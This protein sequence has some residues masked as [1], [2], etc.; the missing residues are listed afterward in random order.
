[1]ASIDRDKLS[2]YLSAHL[3]GEL[4]EQEREALE[5][6]VARD[7]RARSQLEELRQ[8]VELVR[9]LPRRAA[10]PSLLEDLTAAAEREQLLGEPPEEVRRRAPWWASAR[11]LLSAAAAVVITVGGGLYVYFN[12]N[13]AGQRGDVP[14]ET[15]FAAR[16][17]EPV[18][19]EAKSEDSKR[20]GG[21]GLAEASPTVAD[22]L[23][24]GELP[25]EGLAKA[26]VDSEGAPGLR[27]AATMTDKKAPGVGLAVVT[28][29][30]VNGL[31]PAAATSGLLAAQAT[32][33]AEMSTWEQKNDAN[34]LQNTLLVHNFDN[35]SNRLTVLV[36]SEG[37]EQMARAQAANFVV[38]NQYRD[39]A[40]MPEEA[41][42]SNSARAYMEGRPGY[43]YDAGHRAEILFRLPVNEVPALVEALA[44]SDSGARPMQLV[45]GLTLAHGQDEI[46]ELIDRVQR[47]PGE[48][49]ALVRERDVLGPAEG[50]GAYDA[51]AAGEAKPLS[52]RGRAGGVAGVIPA[53]V[54]AE[55]GD[56]PRPERAPDRG[57]A[58]PAMPVK[59]EIG[60]EPGREL[61]E[62]RTGG[63][64][65]PPEQP[66]DVG[67]DLKKMVDR[68]LAGA[69]GADAEEAVKRRAAGKGP[70][71][72]TT[73]RPGELVSK[74][75]EEL[76]RK[77]RRR[78]P[79]MPP[80]AGKAKDAAPEGMVEQ[81]VT[82]VVQFQRASAPPSA[83][84]ATQPA[85][86][87][88]AGVGDGS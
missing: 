25:A 42:V 16:P 38:T 55:E 21:R 49:Y 44:S 82:V 12:I 5:R 77:E 86:P 8:T 2:E 37:D 23:E 40:L 70:P 3:D 88:D 61:G 30:G 87:E 22:S 13:D 78:P 76:R 73:R 28:G 72:P 4:T 48:R 74:A 81:F 83:K 69:R 57:A 17:A 51:G 85:E 35:E 7:A 19:P 52:G 64:A 24:R 6:L 79:G 41:L 58:A 47:P 75:L 68:L 45:L 65:A 10:P 20:I 32:R 60:G 27:A 26:R 66:V 56:K 18:E 29:A 33:L 15:R 63:A 34:F 9:G 43:N 71:K 80:A 54:S 31:V 39:V 1:M 62:K 11:P 59:E 46:V 50:E 36:A 84:T 53:G 14:P 67:G